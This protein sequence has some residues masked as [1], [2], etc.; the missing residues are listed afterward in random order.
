MHEANYNKFMQN[1]NVKQELLNTNGTT[2]AQACPFRAHWCTGY[3]AMDTNCHDQHKWTGMNKFGEIL[4]N[5][6]EEIKHIA[7]TQTKEITQ[8]NDSGACFE[9]E[10]DFWNST[11][12]VPRN[13]PLLQI[14]RGKIMTK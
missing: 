9:P 8:I 2:I 5:L 7:K 1:E 10:I 4:T 14:H 3:F 11:K 12:S 13:R 6:R